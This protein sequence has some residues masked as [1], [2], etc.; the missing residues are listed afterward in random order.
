MK[1]YTT[2]QQRIDIFW[3][4]VNKD[5]SIPAHMPHLGECWEWT[6]SLRKTGYGRFGGDRNDQENLVHRLSW[7]FT[8]GEI[9]NGLWVL[10]KCDNRKC[11]NPAHLFLGTN[12]DN[13]RD[14]TLKGRS[15]RQ[16]GESHGN[17][18][19]TDKQIAEIRERYAA[20]GVL[21]R[22]LAV[23]Y[24]VSRNGVTNIINFVRRIKQT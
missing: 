23:E 15:A 24:G 17:H 7:V 22:E 6:G 1:K 20:G 12:Q 16:F 4:R 14:R 9:P 21:Q 11:V 19:L 13:T 3:S 10:H 18:K 5:G 8:Y 2:K